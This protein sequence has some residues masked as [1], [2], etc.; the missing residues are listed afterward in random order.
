MKSRTRKNKKAKVLLVFGAG[1]AGSE[2]L[3]LAMLFSHGG[4]AVYPILCPS[5]Q[6]WV[7][8]LAIKEITGHSSFT[9]G[10]PQDGPK[11]PK[12]LKQ[13]LTDYSAVM[14]VN[15]SNNE[16]EALYSLDFLK[17]S[18]PLLG[19]K[20]NEPLTMSPAFFLLA[21]SVHKADP[22]AELK[23]LEE[24][25][26]FFQYELP[27]APL[28]YRAFYQGVFS[29]LVSYLSTKKLSPNLSFR[30][31]NSINNKGAK[32]LLEALRERGAESTD[33]AASLEIFF[34]PEEGFRVETARLSYAVE[35]SRLGLKVSFDGQRRLFPKLAEYSAY[36]KFVDF[37]LVELQKQ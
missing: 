34:E 16:L 28:E 36:D 25:Y 20:A 10:S 32:K 9:L 6:G 30:L 2:A 29:K 24:A 27:K 12:W 13:S 5:A 37:L 26:H 3:Y 21:E 33:G 23:G 14:A 19:E 7:S 8:T 31:H 4:F 18:P 22:L 17:P 35:A 11:Q 15:L 1:I